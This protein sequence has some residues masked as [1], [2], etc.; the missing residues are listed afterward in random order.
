MGDGST[1]IMHARHA[2]RQGSWVYL[3]PCGGVAKASWV[4]VTMSTGHYSIHVLTLL[5]IS[6]KTA[7]INLK[8]HRPTYTQTITREPKLCTQAGSGCRRRGLMAAAHAGCGSTADHHSADLHVG[9]FCTWG[10]R[11]RGYFAIH[12]Q[13][14]CVHTHRY[15]ASGSLI[16]CL[17]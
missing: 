10:W 14:L 12:V 7:P 11:I 1:D 6:R 2:A 13:V 4:R 5:G 17:A 8:K 15:V 9:K 16:F 3:R